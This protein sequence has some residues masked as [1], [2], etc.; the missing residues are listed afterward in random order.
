MIFAEK[1]TQLRK[2]NGWSQ[3]ELAERVGVSRQAVSKWEAAGA[4]PELDKLL[5]LSRLFGVSTDFLLRDELEV[6]ESGPPAPPQEQ[7]R[8]SLE[9]ANAFL[10]AREASA[11]RLA[12]GVGLCVASPVALLLLGG[13]AVPS[14]SEAAAGGIGLAILILMV[15]AAVALFVTTGAKSRP[16]G[17]LEGLFETEYGVTGLV[18]EKRRAFQAAHTRCI[19]IGVCLCVGSTLPLLIAGAAD[20]AEAGRAAA[21]AAL[22]VLCALGAGTLTYGG[23]RWAAFD[24]LL[25][26][27]DY[28]RERKQVSP[29]ARTVGMV[30]WLAVTAGYLAYAFWTGRWESAGPIYAVAGILFAGITVALY[31]LKKPKQ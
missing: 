2:K 19:V 13:L 23:V 4:T 26:E 16:Y 14:L 8:V 12:L 7:R 18:R 11:P 27:G 28:T 29:L 31:A 22:L 5:A 17:Y 15:M 30:Y 6:E 24:K 25:Q 21:I 20:A 1:L 10:R 9:E 3:E